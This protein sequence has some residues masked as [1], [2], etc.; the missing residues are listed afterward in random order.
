MITMVDHHIALVAQWIE[1]QFPELGVEG[2]NPFEGTKREGMPK[3]AKRWHTF[4]FCALPLPH[5][6]LR[7]MP[8]L[9]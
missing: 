8:W 9:V 2:S 3:C 7:H 1:H 4:S 5:L 6:V